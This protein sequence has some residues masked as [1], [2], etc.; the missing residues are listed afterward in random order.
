MSIC[1]ELLLIYQRRR[2]MLSL[3][4]PEYRDLWFRQQMLS[5]GETMSY[6]H[7]WGGTIAWPEEEWSGW[8]EYWVINPEGKRYYRY[9]KNEQGEFVGEIAYHYDEEIRHE[10]ANVLIYAPYRGRGYG[11]CA[12]DLLC[13]EAKKNDVSLLYDDIAIDNPA[14]GLF[15]RHGFSEDFR[16]GNRIFLR[17]KL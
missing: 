15:Y 14:I 7:T 13:K 17:K 11:S 16:T 1:A 5:D 9:L 6:N 3:Y 12:L 10:I 8:Y 4:N 2:K